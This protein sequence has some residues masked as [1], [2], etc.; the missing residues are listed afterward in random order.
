MAK[1]YLP[2]Q[3]STRGTFGAVKIIKTNIYTG[4]QEVDHILNTFVHVGKAG[5]ARRLAKKESNYG[6]ISY[7][8]TGTGAGTPATGDLVMFTELFRKPISVTAY[9]SNICTFTTYFS[10]SESNGTLTEVGLFGD[11]ATATTDSGT[12][13][14]HAN[15]TKTKTSSDTLTIEW[16]LTIN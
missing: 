6:H 2:Y 4:E 15:I 16:Q 14:A 8:A 10:T 11:L 7:M 13:Y 9:S 3:D 5:I 12:M 1:I